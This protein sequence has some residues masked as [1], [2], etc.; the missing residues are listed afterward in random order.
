MCT[1]RS[2]PRFALSIDSGADGFASRIFFAAI[3]IL[4]LSKIVRLIFSAFTPSARNWIGLLARFRVNASIDRQRAETEA[5]AAFEVRYPPKSIRGSSSIVLPWI[6]TLR[7]SIEPSASTRTFART[8][9]AAIESC[10]SVA[11]ASTGRRAECKAAWRNENERKSD[12]DLKQFF[13]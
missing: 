4:A 8:S 10:T 5:E 1:A 9:R 6:R 12:H 3:E 2:E 7:A 11:K 13:V